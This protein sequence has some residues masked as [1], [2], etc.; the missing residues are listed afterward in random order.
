MNKEIDRLIRKACGRYSRI[1]GVECRYIK[2]NNKETLRGLNGRPK[3]FDFHS[4]FYM[5]AIVIGN[6]IKI[7]QATHTDRGGFVASEKCLKPLYDYFYGFILEVL[8]SEGSSELKRIGV[9]Y[10]IEEGSKRLNR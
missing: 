2:S 10:S 4:D 1:N 5:L 9:N 6:D 3:G 8:G 7:L